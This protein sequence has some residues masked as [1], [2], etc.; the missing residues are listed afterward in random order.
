[1][2]T[3]GTGGG[4]RRLKRTRKRKGWEKHPKGTIHQISISSGLYSLA[5]SPIISVK[6]RHGP[7]RSTS[8]CL[9]VG[10]G[11]FWWFGVVFVLCFVGGGFGGWGRVGPPVVVFSG[12]LWGL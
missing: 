3:K 2:P 8:L 7:S 10:G 11:G 4:R 6:G 1:V 12:V 9:G 5:D